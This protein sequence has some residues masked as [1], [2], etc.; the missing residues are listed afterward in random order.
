VVD[1]LVRQLAKP[2]DGASLFVFR[3]LLGGTIAVG[4]VRFFVHGWIDAFYRAPRMLFGYWG[5]QW[6]KPLPGAWLEVHFAAV[7][8]L[9]VLFAL[10]VG[11][12]VVAP[13]LFVGFTWLELLDK[14]TYLNHY[15]LVSVL[16]LLMSFMPLG[17]G[18][19][20]AGGW[21]S[22]EVPRIC[23]W[24]LRVQ[25]GLVYFYAGL[26]KLGPDWLLSAQPLRIWLAT[27]TDLPL[28]GPWLSLPAVG[29]L[30]SWCGAAFDLASP[31]LLS[32][33][34]TRVV[35]FVAAAFFHVVTGF[36]F[37]LGIFPW[38]MI[39]GAT[40]FFA[41]DWPVAPLRLGPATAW[42]RPVT[43]V[44]RTLA[45]LAAVHLALQLVLPLRSLLYPNNV[46]WSEEG[47]RFAWK[48]ML[49]EKAGRTTFHVRDPA[50]GRQWQLTPQS[51]LTALQAKMAS[52]QP[53]MILALAH[54]V[55][56]DFRRQ[57]M[58]D[59]EVRA[60]VW[61]SLNGRPSALLVD[62]EVDLAREQDSLLPKRW[63]LPA[64]T[65]TPP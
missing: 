51:E 30:A 45:A 19:S 38:L 8:V 12:R 53:D 59:V 34:R 43:A 31:W 60:E 42:T 18:L 48:V 14:T 65:T 52:T 28:V 22:A 33:R 20:F 1:R 6:V 13:L 16:L 55:A 36:L 32:W 17:R 10:G 57:G 2:V 5:L 62:P 41:P 40:L 25:V 58:P 27:R 11:Y 54:H 3:A 24:V 9:A 44:F 46:L 35:A 56:D 61:V 7:G 50:S 26:A 49:V 23:L 29:Y 47:F 39:A 63:I 21:R 64:P 37:Q 15:Y 4:M